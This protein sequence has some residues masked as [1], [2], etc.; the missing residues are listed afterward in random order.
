MKA[1]ASGQMKRQ[2]ILITHLVLLA[3]VLLSLF[4]PFFESFQRAIIHSPAFVINIR[5]NPQQSGFFGG[6]YFTTYNGFASPIAWFN[7][8]ISILFVAFAQK[9]SSSIKILRALLI[10]FILSNVLHLVHIIAAP[11]LLS[12]SDTLLIGYFLMTFAE[13]GLYVFACLQFP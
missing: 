5:P 1:I 3:C 11:F 2:Y 13:T 4:L 6:G 7:V 12:P 10:L 8:I 9:I